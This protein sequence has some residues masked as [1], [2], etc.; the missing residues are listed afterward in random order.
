MRDLHEYIVR[1]A[2]LDGQVDVGKQNVSHGDML[3]SGCGRVA[4]MR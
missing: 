3:L 2:L 4:R 1:Y